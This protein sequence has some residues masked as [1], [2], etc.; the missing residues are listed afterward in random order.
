MSQHHPRRASRRAS[1]RARIGLLAGLAGVALLVVLSGC[2]SSSK[3]SQ[4]SASATSA[5]AVPAK[6][7]NLVALARKSGKVSF[8]TSADP[9]TAQE[10][11]ST[12]GKRYG[13]KVTFTRLTSGPI[14]AR[15]DAEAQSGHPAADAVVISDEPFFADGLSKGFF[16]PVNAAEVPAVSTIAK[17]F[18]FPG[19]VGVGISRLDGVVVNT[20]EVKSDQVPQSWTDLTQAQWKGQLITDDPR[21]VPIVLGQ[22]KLLDD[23][24]GDSYL[25][26]IAAQDVQFVPSLV[27]G[28][29]SIAAGERKAA[30]GANPLHVAPLKATAPN[31]PVNLTHLKGPDFGFTW[32]AGVSAHSPNPAGGRLFV[33]WLLSPQGQK[34]FNGPGNNSVLPSVQVAGSPPLT[35]KFQTLTSDISSSEKN[36][37]LSLLGL[38]Q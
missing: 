28:I 32:N 27:T 16:L 26:Q 9:H 17:K 35:S 13:L 5:P 24:Y 18:V 37:I 15:Y 38:T 12:F 36:H 25:K 23:T 1:L 14:A 11:A 22:W 29:Q 31:A 4:S 7:G 10:M 8:Y 2:G 33:N 6:G 20:N 3:T 34:I 30:F 21:V 19:S